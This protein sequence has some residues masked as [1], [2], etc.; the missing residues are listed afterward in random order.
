[1]TERYLQHV[2]AEADKQ[3]IF[4]LSLAGGDVALLRAMLQPEDGSSFDLEELLRRL[5]RDYASVHADRARLHDDPAVF[6]QR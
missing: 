1:M 2:V 6:V 4:A 5:E 3:A